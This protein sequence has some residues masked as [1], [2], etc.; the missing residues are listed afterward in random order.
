MGGFHLL[1]SEPSIGR[2]KIEQMTHEGYEV[3]SKPGA[4]T[5]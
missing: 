3:I 4:R 2:S 5:G 1:S